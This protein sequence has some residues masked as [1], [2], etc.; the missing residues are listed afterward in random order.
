VPVDGSVLAEYALLPAAELARRQGAR[1][2]L[3]LVHPWGAEEAAPLGGTAADRTLRRQELEYLRDLQDRLADAVGIESARR[4][5]DGDRAPALAAFAERVQADLLVTSTRARGG[6]ARTLRRDLALRLAH[7]LGCPA[8]LLK[9]QRAGQVPVPPGGFQRLLVALDG[10]RLAEASLRPALE[11]SDQA[12][13][14]VTL[15]RVIAPI[16]PGLRERH[17]RALAYLLGLA[18]NLEEGGV[19]A[20][21]RVL[22]R[23]HAGRAIAAYA[24]LIGADLVAVATR[25]RGAARRTALGSVVDTALRSAHAPVLICHSPT[26]RRAT[27]VPRRRRRR[28]L[29]G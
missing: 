18:G 6:V 14:H 17:R 16:S 2:W 23:A 1:L 19:Q 5:L 20:D 10:S 8:L 15:L 28:A 27:S 26:K 13:R 11:L 3:A 9:P 4:M 25:E 29:V 21:V 24:D 7:A 22:A 12:H